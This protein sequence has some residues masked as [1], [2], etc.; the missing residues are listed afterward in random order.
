VIEKI[1]KAVREWQ[2]EATLAQIRGKIDYEFGS[3]E[4]VRFYE[5]LDGLVE[6]GSLIYNVETKVYR[7]GEG[8]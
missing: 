2:G 5:A 1:K 3:E 7:E 4:A 8:K 6:D